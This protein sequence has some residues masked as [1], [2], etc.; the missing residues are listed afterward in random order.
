MAR[1]AF[2]TVQ[3]GGN[4]PPQIAV[5]RALAARGHELHLLGDPRTA[6]AAAE[7]GASFTAIDELSFWDPTRPRS[8][9]AAIGEAVRLATDDAARERIRTELIRLRPDVAITDPLVAV[10]TTAALAAGVPTAVLSHTFP[11]YWTGVLAHGPVGILAALRGTRLG[12]VY[13]AA[14]LRIVTGDRALDPAPATSDWIWTGSCETGV[15]AQRQDPPRVLVSLSTTSLPGQPDVYRRVIDALGTLPVEAVVTT[16]GQA[17]PEDL[18]VP[19]NV[20][21]HQRLPHE[22]LLPHLSLVIGHGGY[23]TTLRA[24]VHGVPLLILPGHPMLDQPMVGKAV[25][26]AG[27]GLSMKH[28]ASPESIRRAVLRLLGEPG[29]TTAAQRIGLRL[30]GIDGAAAAADALQALVAAPRRVRS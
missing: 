11:T 21:V 5:G 22:Q 16:G 10:G 29:F 20:Q 7:M 14:D 17:L 12:R 9:A 18:I 8:V 19:P 24:L 28:T 25:A 30:R 15:P 23:S 1:F 26:D 3:G 6:A 13:G 27:A 4:L 2:I